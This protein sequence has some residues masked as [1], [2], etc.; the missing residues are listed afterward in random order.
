[1]IDVEGIIDRTQHNLLESIDNVLGYTIETVTEFKAEREA[2]SEYYEGYLMGLERARK[3][4][5]EYKQETKIE[6][7]QD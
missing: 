7:E 6:E 3:V 4:I 1:M 5:L 2:Q